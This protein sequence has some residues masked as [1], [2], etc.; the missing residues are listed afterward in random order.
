[1]GRADCG[2]VFNRNPRP[3]IRDPTSE[4]RARPETRSPKSHNRNPKLEITNHT[5][6]IR[7]PNSRHL[8]RDPKPSNPEPDASDPKPETRRLKP[9]TRNLSPETRNLKPP[10]RNSK[11]ETANSKP[12]TRNS[13][14]KSRNPNPETSNPGPT[15]SLKPE[16]GTR[17][18]GHNLSPTKEGSPKKFFGDSTGRL[19]GDGGRFLCKPHQCLALSPQSINLVSPIY[20]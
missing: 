19:F 17:D 12:T 1:M 6:T 7:D 8:P 3:D 14:Q 4:I 16:I 11:P 10:A 9:G 18:Q 20:C 13:R 2:Q 5:P 15:R